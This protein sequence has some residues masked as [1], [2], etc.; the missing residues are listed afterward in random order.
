MTTCKIKNTVE[1]VAKLKILMAAADLAC[2][3]ENPTPRGEIREDQ[4]LIEHPPE[5]LA[6]GH[7]LHQ[8]P[9]LYKTKSCGCPK[10]V[11][12]M[13]LHLVTRLDQL[14]RHEAAIPKSNDHHWRPDEVVRSRLES[15]VLQVTKAFGL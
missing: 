12:Y 15:R 9:K 2:C 7:R 10:A 13:Q 6:M 4:A 14:Y 8:N 5:Q 11:S 3:T 1:S